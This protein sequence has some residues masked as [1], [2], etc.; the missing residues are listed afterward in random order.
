MINGSGEGLNK[1]PKLTKLT[2]AG[3]GLNDYKDTSY[4]RSDQI[5]DYAMLQKEKEF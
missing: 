2:C 1:L 4:T 3:P 5:K